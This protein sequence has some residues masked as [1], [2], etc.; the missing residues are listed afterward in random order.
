MGAQGL[1]YA[2]LIQ[3]S[4]CQEKR[5][6]VGRA[7]KNTSCLQRSGD[8]SVPLC[9]RAAHWTMER[10]PSELM[11]LASLQSHQRPV[12]PPS[13]R[14]AASGRIPL[15]DRSVL[16]DR[17]IRTRRSPLPLERGWG[18]RPGFRGPLP[19]SAPAERQRPAGRCAHCK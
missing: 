18:V 1:G 9:A 7:T 16:D 2:P 14:P 6:D 11:E 5:S 19:W 4:D 12:D 15:I 8:A 17:S 3:V 13:R 10:L